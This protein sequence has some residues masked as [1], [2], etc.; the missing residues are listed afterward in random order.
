MT[1]QA[2]PARTNPWKSFWDRGGWWK[3]LLFVAVYL[4]AYTYLP[5]LAQPF[6]G[7]AL[8]V[9]SALETP[10]SVFFGIMLPLVI[11]SILLIVFA[12][13]VRWLPVPLFGRQPVRGRWWMWF[14]PALILIPILLRAFG[15]DYSQYSVAVIATVFLT[16]AFV[17]FSEELLTRGVVV[18]LLRRAG[19]NEWV[20]AF[21]SALF[22]AALHSVN[23]FT[24]QDPQTVLGTLFYTF[25]FG[26]MM[27]LVMRVTGSIVWA[28]VLHALTDPTTMLATG[29]VDEQN[30]QTTNVLIGL[31]AP[32]T[33]LMFVGALV[34]LVFIRGDANGRAAAEEPERVAAP[35]A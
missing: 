7:D 23:F 35:K 27:Y 8:D 19:H 13:T 15:T 6:M 1:E 5:F 32:A 30:V 18:V 16:G 17:G 26:L 22:F 12:L 24:G 3:A 9:D 14:A 2:T 11:G 4:A 10:A 33:V 31:V 29:G 28:M 34:M 21:L 20:V 25:C